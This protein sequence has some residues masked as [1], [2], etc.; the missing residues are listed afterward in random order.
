[1]VAVSDLTLDIPSFGIFVLL[2]ANGCVFV[3]M[4]RQNDLTDLIGLVNP[5]RSLSSVVSLAK[6]LA[7]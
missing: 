5:R 2:G 7:Q 4:S 1:M 6:L 3:S